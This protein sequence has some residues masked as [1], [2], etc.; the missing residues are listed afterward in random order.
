MKGFEIE[1]DLD[2]EHIMW[3]YHLRFFIDLKRKYDTFVKFRGS[4][5]FLEG[6]D[7]HRVQCAV[8]NAMSKAKREFMYDL[9][10]QSNNPDENYGPYMDLLS[11]QKYESIRK[12]HNGLIIFT[13]KQFMLIKQELNEKFGYMGQFS[14]QYPLNYVII[15]LPSSKKTQLIESINYL[16]DNIRNNIDQ[17]ITPQNTAYYSYRARDLAVRNVYKKFYSMKM[18]DVQAIQI[19]LIFDIRRMEEY[20]KVSF[21]LKDYQSYVMLVIQGSSD[22]GCQEAMSTLENHL[23]NKILF[24]ISKEQSNILNGI[25]CKIVKME[26]IE[27]IG[28]RLDQCFGTEILKRITHNLQKNDFVFT[29]IA[30][31]HYCRQ[32]QM[33][34]ENNQLSRFTNSYYHSEVDKQIDSQ[35]IQQ[36]ISIIEQVDSQEIL[37]FKNNQNSDSKVILPIKQQIEKQELLQQLDPQSSE[38]EEQQDMKQL[39]IIKNHKIETLQDKIV[40]EFFNYKEKSKLYL[41]LNNFDEGQFQ[42]DFDAYCSTNYCFPYVI[43]PDYSEQNQLKFIIELLNSNDKNDIAQIID[44]LD[45]YMNCQIILGIKNVKRLEQGDQEM[46]DELCDDYNCNLKIYNCD[47]S[48]KQVGW[49]KIDA[50]PQENQNG[51]DIVFIFSNVIHCFIEQLKEKVNGL[52]QFSK[53]T[54]VTLLFQSQF[55]HACKQGEIKKLNQFAQFRFDDCYWTAITAKD[56]K[57]IIENIKENDSK[58]FKTLLG[59]QPVIQNDPIILAKE[60]EE[61]DFYDVYIPELYCNYYE[62]LRR[63]YLDHQYTEEEWKQV[64]VD[65]SEKSF[66][67]DVTVLGIPPTHLEPIIEIIDNVERKGKVIESINNLQKGVYLLGKTRNVNSETFD[68]TMNNHI[69][70][71]IVNIK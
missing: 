15:F 52:N 36:D 31:W 7:Q 48:A 6:T 1:L 39:K 23:K 51:K 54:I 21:T 49:Q 30:L 66:C 10:M 50:Q 12:E 41:F 43:Q 56:P 33:N 53:K 45:H 22:L 63:D 24:Q 26:E 58:I 19:F 61:R 8:Q 40:V 4:K 60:G 59:K 17:G 46:L 64:Q 13:K 25:D 65:S 14:R 71:S 16:V 44:F 55:E 34:E 20:F 68:L 47:L 69:I 57:A 11:N 29:E 70:S 42:S 3:M 27:E 37:P 62:K 38:E 2:A 32:K 5:A 35:L 67:V 28:N 18:N 9:L